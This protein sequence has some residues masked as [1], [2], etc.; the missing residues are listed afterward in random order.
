M[1]Q[2]PPLNTPLRPTAVITTITVKFKIKTGTYRATH[3]GGSAKNDS[4]G[5]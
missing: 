4:F 2:W 3:N 1:A 5:F